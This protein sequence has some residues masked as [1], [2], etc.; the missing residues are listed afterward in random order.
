MVILLIYNCCSGN[1]Y[2]V[3]L[4]ANRIYVSETGSLTVISSTSIVYPLWDSITIN[5]D[6]AV[7]QLPSAVSYT[8]EYCHTVMNMYIILIIFRQITAQ[9]FICAI[10]QCF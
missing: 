6:I 4:G 9:A 1:R 8:C 3:I 10:Y 2:E 5:N 7:V